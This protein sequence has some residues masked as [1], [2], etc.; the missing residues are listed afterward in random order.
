MHVRV[1]NGVL[2]MLHLQP[3]YQRNLDPYAGLSIVI[4]FAW[5]WANDDH[6]GQGPVARAD[7][8][9]PVDVNAT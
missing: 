4:N 7:W 5:L 6:A 2:V 3:P 1:Q 8:E 9:L